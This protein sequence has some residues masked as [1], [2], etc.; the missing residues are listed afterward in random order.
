MRRARYEHRGWQV[1]VVALRSSWRLRR[2]TPT[3]ASLKQSQRVGATR[4]MSVGVPLHGHQGG[5]QTAGLTSVAA[6]PRHTRGWRRTQQLLQLSSWR[7]ESPPV[8]R[9]I[10]GERRSSS[11][12]R[13]G[14]RNAAVG[15]GA[16]SSR[17]GGAKKS[18]G[19]QTSDCPRRR[20][21][22]GCTPCRVL[23]KRR[24]ICP[25][26]VI[27]VVNKKV[28]NCRYRDQTCVTLES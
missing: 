19:G 27:V 13:G 6:V 11:H 25:I 5:G 23:M 10:G 9:M 17:C 4:V 1:S 18:Q 12:P 26:H 16:G 21:G 22:S 15:V 28:L 7:A 24:R 14:G 8:V 2:T 20:R 3:G